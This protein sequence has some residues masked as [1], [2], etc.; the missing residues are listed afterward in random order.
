MSQVA[1]LLQKDTE[2]EELVAALR[3]WDVR[4]LA[5]SDA[6]AGGPLPPA[7]LLARLSS[8]DDPRLRLA[9]IPLFILHPDLAGGVSQ[10]A[11]VLDAASRT[12]L[13]A[14]Y[15]AAVY[16]QQIWS[17][18]LGFYLPQ[19]AP[20][21]DLFSVELGLPPPVDHYGKTGLRGLAAWHAAHS[22]YPFNWL[23][24]YQRTMDLLFAQLKQEARQREHSPIG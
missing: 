4:F 8:N 16:L 5:P 14:G 24:S 21:P 6:Q 13:V 7:E 20:L 22:L 2:R 19:V 18:R 15:M 17:V 1:E 12:E 10:L 11:S 9:L 3:A 23:A